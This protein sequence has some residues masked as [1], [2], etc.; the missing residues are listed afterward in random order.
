M[1]EPTTWTLQVTKYPSGELFTTPYD[2]YE[3]A[4]GAM[5]TYLLEIACASAKV[6]LDMQSDVLAKNALKLL[7]PDLEPGPCITVVPAGRIFLAPDPKW[8]DQEANRA[9]GGA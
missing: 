5:A 4:A 7:D 8:Y 1:T 9:A 3:E 6:G 2:T